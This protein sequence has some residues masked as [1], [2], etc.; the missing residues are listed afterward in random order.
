[1]EAAH[2]TLNVGET[3]KIAACP[4]AY[5]DCYRIRK[6]ACQEKTFLYL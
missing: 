5:K 1:M 2:L 3:Q 6:D 4:S